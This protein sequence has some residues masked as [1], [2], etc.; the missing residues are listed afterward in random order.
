MANKSLLFRCFILAV[1]A[2]VTLVFAH[3]VRYQ[4]VEPVTMGAICA[5]VATLQCRL[6]D[7]AIFVL[8]ESRLGWGAIALVCLAYFTN[9]FFVALLAWCI[10]CIG[11]VLYTPELCAVA[12]LLAGLLTIRVSGRENQAGKAM[13]TQ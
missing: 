9:V 13:H 8:Q 5:K 2:C 1:I 7:V 6:R 10:A 12:L 11:L 3:Y 4:L